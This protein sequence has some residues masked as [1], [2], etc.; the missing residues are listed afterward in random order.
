MERAKQNAVNLQV[1]LLILIIIIM[2]LFLIIGHRETVKC[3]I[4][5]GYIE[6]GKEKVQPKLEIS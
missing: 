1:L 4:A 2:F 6:L 5:F 3:K